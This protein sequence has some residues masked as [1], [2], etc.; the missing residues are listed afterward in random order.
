MRPLFFPYHHREHSAVRPHGPSRLSTSPSSSA[1]GHTSLLASRPLISANRVA[2]WL[3]R[4]SLLHEL[5]GPSDRRHRPAWPLASCSAVR[6]PGVL[7][8]RSAWSKSDSL[9]S[10]RPSKPVFGYKQSGTSLPLCHEALDT[11]CDHMVHLQTAL[12]SFTTTTLRGY[13]SCG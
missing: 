8:R 7:G 13:I 9:K 6:P 4:I 10:R 11:I 2:S 3:F 12:G 1:V 5:S